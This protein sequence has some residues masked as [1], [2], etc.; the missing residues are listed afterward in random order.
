MNTRHWLRSGLALVA[1]ATFAMAF[2]G[3]FAR[4]I[5]QQQVS[6][7]ALLIWRFAL[8]VPLFWAGA[9]WINRG[10]PKPPLSPRQWMLC[11]F[12]GILFFVSA[13]CD[14]HAIDQLG[15]SLSRLVLYLF[16]AM[17]MV[18]EAMEQRRL[19]GWR[20]LLVFAGA[21]LGTA[22][23]LLP[24]WHGGAVG[25][26]GLAFGFGAAACYAV[27]WRTSQSLTRPLGSVRFNQLSNSVT[28][29]AMLV[30][31]LPALPAS[32]LRISPEALGWM[33]L[34][35]VFSTVV[36]FFLL[37]EGLSRANAAEAGMLSMFG[38]VVTVVMALVVFPDERLSPL[39]WLGMVVV[40]VSVGSLKLVKG[41]T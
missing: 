28:L 9:A 19:P 12:T 1:V 5:Y 6:V 41:K 13:W 31:L 38:P 15:A 10:K 33:L 26:A 25:A 11:G 4:L 20:R 34:M 3:I 22:L 29:I 21:W 37:F 27:F 24:G 40:L 18:L 23:L 2:K 17:V 8:A 39:Q 7:N 35:V 14:F 32:E 36:P 30:F 16:P